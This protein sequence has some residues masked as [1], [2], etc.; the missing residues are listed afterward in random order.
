MIN[1][2]YTLLDEGKTSYS[3]EGNHPLAIFRTSEDYDSLQLALSDIATEVENLHEIVVGDTS[4]DVKFYLGGDWKFLAIVT[5][6][7]H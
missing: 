4:Y 7:L 6:E 5:G 3:Y 1:F 2:T